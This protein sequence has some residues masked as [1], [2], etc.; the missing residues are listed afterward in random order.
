M[1]RKV[2]DCLADT[3]K[4]ILECSIE[5]AKTCDKKRKKSMRNTWLDQVFQTQMNGSCQELWAILDCCLL[6]DGRLTS[7]LPAWDILPRP[8]CLLR[9]RQLFWS[10][11]V[12]THRSLMHFLHQAVQ[13]KP[14]IFQA[15]VLFYCQTM[16][17]LFTKLWLVL[18]T[19]INTSM[20]KKVT[21]FNKR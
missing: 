5:A 6:L 7:K 14:S 12:D 13:T 10:V 3:G 8:S 18:Y 4:A 1:L 17:E 19:V 11:L 9:T 16:R 21:S 15:L 2:W 20:A